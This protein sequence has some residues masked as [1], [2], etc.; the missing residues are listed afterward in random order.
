MYQKVTEKVEG[1]TLLKRVI[2]PKE[3]NVEMVAS[4]NGDIMRIKEY[5]REDEKFT[6]LQKN[7]NQHP[8][9]SN[10]V[11]QKRMVKPGSGIAKIQGFLLANVR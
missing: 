8:T 7:W 2:S 10:V 6:Y 4:S 1:D 9:T 5:N 11:L 3:E